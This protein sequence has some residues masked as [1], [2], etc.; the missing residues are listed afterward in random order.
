[1]ANIF[2]IHKALPKL[3]DSRLSNKVTEKLERYTDLKL[4]I[5]KCGQ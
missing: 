5:Q 4:E 2:M 3:G 1:M